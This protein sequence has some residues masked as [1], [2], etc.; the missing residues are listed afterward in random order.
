MPAKRSYTI[1]FKLKVIEYAEKQ[2]NHAAARNFDVD[3]RRV[4][5]WR[6]QKD[7]LVTMEK[8]KMRR[9]GG[10]RRVRYGDIYRR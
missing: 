1:S 10:G 5:E 4:I 7:E 9:P 8:S 3:R 2:S 6:Q